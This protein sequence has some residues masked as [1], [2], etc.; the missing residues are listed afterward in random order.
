MDHIDMLVD[1]VSSKG[2][3]TTASTNTVTMFAIMENCVKKIAQK[4]KTTRI[5]MLVFNMKYMVS[6]HSKDGKRQHSKKYHSNIFP[7]NLPLFDSVIYEESLTKYA[8]PV[9]VTIINKQ[10]GSYALKNSLFLVEMIK[11]SQMAFQDTYLGTIYGRTTSFKIANH[12]QVP[13]ANKDMY[14]YMLE[15]EIGQGNSWTTKI[16][17]H[18]NHDIKSFITNSNLEDTSMKNKSP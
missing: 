15:P 17:I 8:I 1:S 13:L 11:A 5:I 3:K 6:N 12:A 7:V 16:V 2:E 4:V 9:L 14:K 10:Q 18:S